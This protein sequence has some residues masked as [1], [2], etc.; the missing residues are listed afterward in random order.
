MGVSP[1]SLE[2]R[3]AAKVL[4][5]VELCVI[6]IAVERG[7]AY[8]RLLRGASPFTCLIET[9]AEGVSW[10]GE[11]LSLNRHPTWASTPNQ[12]DRIMITPRTLLTAHE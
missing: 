9:L 4:G 12:L 7:F 5:T 2:S 10:V 11:D 6:S 3:A 8:R 1:G